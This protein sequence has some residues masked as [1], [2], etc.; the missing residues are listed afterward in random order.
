MLYILNYYANCE[1]NGTAVRIKTSL[2]L[3]KKEV[4]GTLGNSKFGLDEFNK[5]HKTALNDY[6]WI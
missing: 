5:S 4:C 6:I 2:L 1:K 3:V